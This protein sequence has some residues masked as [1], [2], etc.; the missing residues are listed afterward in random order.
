VLSLLRLNEISSGQIFIDEQDISLVPPSEIRQRI[1]C[2]SQEPF[3]FPGTIKQNADPLNVVSSTEII[4]A[5]QSVGVWGSL[6]TSYGITGEELLESNLD[7][8]VLS[9]GHK[10]LFCLARALL[11]TSKILILDEPTSR[12][13]HVHVHV[14]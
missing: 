3:L 7:E 9:Q 4:D 1:S 2:L 11:K 12:Y 10:Q 13:V 14:N 6:T 8:S 5:L